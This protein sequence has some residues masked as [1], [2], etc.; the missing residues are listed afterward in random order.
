MEKMEKRDKGGGSSLRS[1]LIKTMIGVILIA[2]VVAYLGFVSV[3]IIPSGFKGVVLTWGEVTSIVD[4]GLRFITP[5]AQ[6]IVLMDMTIRKAETTENAASADLQ[7]VS[8]TVAVNYQLD[9]GYVDVIYKTLRSDYE[10]RV[11]NPNIQE[12]IKAA[13]AMFTAEELVTRR[14]EV[15]MQFDTVLSNKLKPYHITVL[16]VSITNFQFSP[17]FAQAVEAKVVAAQRALEAKNK[18]E[19][20]RYEAQ[21]QVIE[22]EAY[23]NATVTKAEADAE[24]L[25]LR[26]EQLDSLILQWTALE[27]WDGKLPTFMGSGAIPFIQIPVNETAKP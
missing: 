11:I 6:D 10:E 22:A 21:R 26:R 13:T 2:I 18:L 4:P 15:K 16:S 8:T 9:P 19:Q 27:R 25:R 20:I 12:S 1:K 24:A 23:Y 14:P 7:E 17:Q 3:R 5:V